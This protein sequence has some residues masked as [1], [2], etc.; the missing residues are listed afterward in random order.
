MDERFLEI[1]EKYGAKAASYL[2]KEKG[3]SVGDSNL[4]PEERNNIEVANLI[5]EGVE[6]DYK[7]IAARLGED[8]AL[9]MSYNFKK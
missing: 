2:M 1:A 9:R 4:T 3:L 5:R 8:V 6:F 7:D